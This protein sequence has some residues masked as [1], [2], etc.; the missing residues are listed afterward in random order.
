[1]NMGK[2]GADVHVPVLE[3]EVAAFLQLRNDG[4]YIDA[5][6]GLGGHSERILR[7]IPLRVAGLSALNGMVRLPSWPENVWKNTVK[8][9]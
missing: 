6:L 4:V 7:M 5:T 2:N 1:M 9:S 8:G 3:D